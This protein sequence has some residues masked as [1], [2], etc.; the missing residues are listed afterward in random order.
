MGLSTTHGWLDDWITMSGGHDDDVDDA[1]GCGG[2]KNP[3]RVYF[4]I[5]CA[6]TMANSCV[7]Y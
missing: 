2:N 5:K 3:S 7:F 4:F 6:F 1:A